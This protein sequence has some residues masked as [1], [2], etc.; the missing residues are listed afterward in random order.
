MMSVRVGKAVSRQ[1]KRQYVEDGMLVLTFVTKYW[2]YGYLVS[3]MVAWTRW[4]SKAVG[5]L[6]CIDTLVKICDGKACLQKS[7][8]TCVWTHRASL[9]N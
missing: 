6:R 4:R 8:T 7:M 3:Y 9:C 5:C 2:K 1:S